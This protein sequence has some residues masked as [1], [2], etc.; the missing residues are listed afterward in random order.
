MSPRLSQI[1]QDRISCYLLQSDETISCEPLCGHSIT[2]DFSHQ[3]DPQ[4][5]RDRYE[6]R[7]EG[8]Q[9]RSRRERAFRRVVRTRISPGCWLVAL[10]AIIEGERLVLSRWCIGAA[11]ISASLGPRTAHTV[12]PLSQVL[13]EISYTAD[14]SHAE[15]HAAALLDCRPLRKEARPS[16][17]FHTC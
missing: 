3:H 11:H 6:R 1:G 7:H 4:A 17:A 9:R 10:S 8:E 15:A 5:F 14:P 13:R 2:A 16:F 12:R